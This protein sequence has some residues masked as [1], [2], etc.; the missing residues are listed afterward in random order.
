MSKDDKLSARLAAAIGVTE[1]E[2]SSMVEAAKIAAAHYR[3]LL[4]EAARELRSA[5]AEVERLKGVLE[6]LASSE[7]FH[8]SHVLVGI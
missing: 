2:L 5:E 4:I 8:Q 3:P 7:A 1:T 6:R